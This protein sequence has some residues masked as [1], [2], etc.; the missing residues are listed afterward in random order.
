MQTAHDPA[1][2]W[3]L[4]DSALEAEMLRRTL[5][6]IGDVELFADGAMVL[7]RLANGVVPDVIIL[8]WQ[9]PSMSGLELARFVRE[10]EAWSKIPILMLTVYGRKQDV[11][12]AFDAGANDY[13]TKPFDVTELVAR[14][15]TLA[16][17]SRLQRTEARRSRQ[18]Q[19]VAE[20]GAALTRARTIEAMERDATAAILAHARVERAAI[21]DAEG[22]ATHVTDLAVPASLA[23][24]AIAHGDRLE[25]RLGDRFVALFPLGPRARPMGVL[26]IADAS[27]L[28]PLVLD[29]IASVRDML[30]LGMARM[31]AETARAEALARERIARAEAETANT[32]KD[33][34][35]AMVSHELRTPLNA[36]LGWTELLLNRDDIDGERGRHG[37]RV[38]ERN[39]RAQAKLVDDL[40]DISRI[41]SGKLSIETGRAELG[42][43]VGIVIE[44]LRPTAQARGVEIVDQLDPETRYELNGDAGRLQQIVWNLVSNAVKFTESGGRVSVRMERDGERVHV[45]V[46]DTGRGIDRSFLPHVFE[47]YRQADTSSR[48]EKSGLG[49]GLAI[50][51]HLAQLHGGDIAAASEGIG[52]GS[53]FTLTLPLSEL[54]FASGPT[55]TDPPPAE[56]HGEL[57]RVRVVI[58]EDDEDAREL[59]TALLVRYGA[60]VEAASTARDAFDLVRG[61]CPDVLVSDIAMPGEDGLSLIRR[62]RELG[63]TEGGH[64][65]AV[66]LTAYARPKDR[67]AALRAGFHAHVSKPVDAS[68]L[69]AVVSAL[70]ETRAS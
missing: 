6:D 29:E 8:D 64:V 60:T 31:R 44:A 63:P 55:S 30:S 5:T 68:E 27:P 38:I 42:S 21:V 14:V 7:E 43:I 19:L 2:L 46:A 22:V 53:T 33:D 32:S 35:L 59:L 24:A 57:R 49:L 69:V 52:R 20:I 37:L 50:A 48:R 11:V 13:V 40:L 41:V 62:V 12:A 23:Q 34:F 47:R 70:L 56:A 51:Y 66:A 61:T 16:R 17:S 4:E 39:A 58:A 1:L 26:A 36:I 67:V 10:R 65:T 25:T 9:L 15:R 3:I 28:D 54:S 45:V 18:Y